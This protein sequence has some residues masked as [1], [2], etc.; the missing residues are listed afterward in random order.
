M[1][2]NLR[3][4]S[5]IIR[6]SLLVGLV[7][8]LFGTGLSLM[9]GPDVPPAVLA[10]LVID[11]CA[12]GLVL[13]LHTRRRLVHR[14]KELAA[15]MDRG[16]EGDLTVKVL[17]TSHDELGMLNDNFNTMME[18]LLGMAARVNG[19]IGELRQI[20]GNIREVSR[21]GV[22]ASQLQSEGVQQTFTA[23]QEI[24][25]S[26]NEV[27]QAVDGLS[28]SAGENASSILQMSASIEEVIVHV[29]T[30][31]A[32]VEEVSASIIEMAEAEKEIGRNVNSLMEEATSTA[33]RVAQMDA[34]IMQVGKNAMAAAD[35]TQTVRTDAESGQ[36]TVMET[37]FGM[38]EIGRSSRITFDAID[39]L[40]GRVSNIGK[41]LLV[42]D[43]LAEQ[44]NLLALNASIIAAQA[45]EHGKG[46]AVVADEIKGLAKRTTNSTRE[47]TGIIKGVQEETQR[48]VE[49]IAQS[50]KRIA[51]GEKLSQRSGE[52]LAKI[53][54]GVVQAT[55]QVTEIAATTVEQTKGSQEMHLA[56][57]RVAEMVKQIARSTREQER[58]GELIMSA[59]ERMK[60]LTSQVRRSTQEQSAAGTSIVHA[61]EDITMMI[62]NIGQACEQQM[63]SSQ[64]IVKAVEDFR[65]TTETSQDVTRV[66][67]G[68][69]SGLARQIDLLQKEMAG[70]RL[71]KGE[72]PELDAP[73]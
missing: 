12:I 22:N 50:E 51:E 44:T 46:F 6:S 24:N 17:S 30:L 29:E 61:T 35:I 39:N 42:I 13:W 62:G 21:R 58:G 69:V 7:S 56:M 64:R 9:S 36:E 14:V 31:S 66:M 68:A 5:T 73:G 32:A 15:A 55:T 23:V 49:A 34:S 70:F 63:E 57:E 11:I 37:I 25:Q 65:G 4:G 54:S 10:A 19:S 71:A 27:A 72:V 33:A 16:A 41:I 45:G 26:V 60:E 38:S 40:S 1:A 59:A 52:A 67:N 18:R 2:R 8:A 28:R 48:A 47:I 43:E 53:V 3:L 20:A